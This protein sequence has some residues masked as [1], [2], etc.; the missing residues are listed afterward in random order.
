MLAVARTVAGWPGAAHALPLMPAAGLALVAF[1]GL[2][3]CLWR[4]PWRLAVV[5]ALALGLALT[6]ARAPPD[7]LV[8][9][10]ARYFAVRAA[11]G[12]LWA[13]SVRSNYTVDSWLRRDGLVSA[14]RW[15]SLGEASGDGRLRCDSL[16]CVYRVGATSVALART[17]DALWDDCGEVDVVVAAVAV[18][19]PCG[20]EAV[21]DRID[22]WRRGAHAIRF[23]RDGPRVESVSDRRGDRPWVLP[24]RRSR[25]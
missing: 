10:D 17:E 8:S 11:D 23:T 6:G 3:L 24:R 1:G 5:P 21:V 14:R 19:V 12:G 25:D 4:R 2:W 20:A 7:V 15:P 22:L 13:T 18:F 9:D 16:G